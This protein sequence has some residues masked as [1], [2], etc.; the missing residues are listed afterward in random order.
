MSKT[1]QIVTKA[2]K[3]SA[4]IIEQFCQANG[5]I[6]LP[7]LNLMESAARWSRQSSTKSE[8]KPWN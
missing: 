1:Y 2:A 3:E 7:L 6:L 8:S 5:Q 4:A